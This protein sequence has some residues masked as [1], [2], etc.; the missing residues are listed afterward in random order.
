MSSNMLAQYYFWWTLTLG[1]WEPFILTPNSRWLATK[2]MISLYV[3]SPTTSKNMKWP[4]GVRYI[5]RINNNPVGYQPTFLR[6]RTIF[7]RPHGSTRVTFRIPGSRISTLWKS[8]SGSKCAKASSCIFTANYLPGHVGRPNPKLFRNSNVKVVTL[9]WVKSSN[10]RLG[11]HPPEQFL[12]SCSIAL[13]GAARMAPCGT[14]R[15]LEKGGF[16]LFEI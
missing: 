14:W 1:R 16:S 13:R 6:L 8:Y 12:G 11:L 4:Q 7:D 3:G 15:P 9:E 10:A 2:Q 5:A